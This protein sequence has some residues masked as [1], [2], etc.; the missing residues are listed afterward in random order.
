MNALSRLGLTSA[1]KPV[2]DSF[3]IINTSIHSLGARVSSSKKNETAST[4][5]NLANKFKDS[6]YKQQFKLSQK[7]LM[8]PQLKDNVTKLGLDL[9]NALAKVTGNTEKYEANIKT[10]LDLSLN[11]LEA[12]AEQVTS[13]HTLTVEQRTEKLSQLHKAA[14]TVVSD[15]Q[16]RLTP[17]SLEQNI[18]KWTDRLNSIIPP[19]LSGEAPTSPRFADSKLLGSGATGKVYL[20]TDTQTGEKVAVKTLLFDVSQIAIKDE[21][22][23]E[24]QEAGSSTILDCLKNL[25]AEFSNESSIPGHPN[26]NTAT[27]IVDK[28]GRDIGKLPWDQV[29]RH[30]ELTESAEIYVVK[31]LGI[32]GGADTFMA[33][34]LAPEQSDKMVA[35]LE[36]SAESGKS[37]NPFLGMETKAQKRAVAQEILTGFMIQD[38][39][40]GLAHAHENG[41]IHCD[42]KPENF[43]VGDSQF[44]VADFGAS[45]RT[46]NAK[47]HQ[48]GSPPYI[49]PELS[50]NNP[51]PQSDLFSLGISTMELLKLPSAIENQVTQGNKASCAAAQVT[52]HDHMSEHLAGSPQQNSL[53]ALAIKLSNPDSAQRGTA[54]EALQHPAFEQLKEFEGIRSALIQ[55]LVQ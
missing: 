40:K 29:V 4:L 46:E 15:Y 48:G 21:L 9:S 25:H 5:M 1:A 27:L 16:S 28:D 23:M 34:A 3:R 38:G 8:G 35:F 39:L 18:G 55:V 14:V 41:I 47:G 44:C 26:L 6:A 22:M 42:I 24:R 45:V 10:K 49:A 52:I 11:G 37:P 32:N 54:Q 13:D 12:K 43:L 51:C 36:Q 53:E 31:P 2:A 20:S 7:T 17:E 30:L 50:A 19:S 33:K